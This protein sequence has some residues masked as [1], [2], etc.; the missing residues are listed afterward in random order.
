MADNIIEERRNVIEHLDEACLR[1]LADVEQHVEIEFMLRNDKSKSYDFQVT[2]RN[3]NNVPIKGRI[4]YYTP[5]EPCKIAHELLHVKCSYSLGYDK[6]IY[7]IVDSLS[8]NTAKQVL[9]DQMCQSILNQTEH[10]VFYK[11]Y[12]NMGYDSVKFV[13]SI[14]LDKNN[15]DKFCN[16]YNRSRISM[17]DVSNLLMALHHIILFP[18]DNRF[19][20]EER[21]LKHMERELYAA[22]KNFRD[23][24]PDLAMLQNNQEY[25]LE[26]T[27]RRLFE[28]INAWC[29]KHEQ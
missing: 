10:Y 24:L 3:D 9:T 8:S 12:A 23:E 16:G 7:D 13:E 20:A 14:N 29:I 21:Q 27:Y 4:R 19:S 11:A 15:W 6:V 1:L 22:F 25:S 26:P 17:A 18:I 2:A 5:I 28:H